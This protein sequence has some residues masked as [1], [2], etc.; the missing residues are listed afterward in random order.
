MGVPKAEIESNL[1]ISF[2]KNNTTE[3][4]DKLVV[5]LVLAVKDYLLK[6]S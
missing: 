2:S 4:V 3:E 5:E 1:R 6:V